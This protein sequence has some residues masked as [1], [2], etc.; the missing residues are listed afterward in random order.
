V[1]A[2]WLL[3]MLPLFLATARW[4]HRRGRP[5]NLGLLATLVVVAVLFFVVPF[6]LPR[7]HFDPSG[8]RTEVPLLL[9]LF[10][11]A[12]TVVPAVSVVASLVQVAHTPDRRAS[13]G[14]PVA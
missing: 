1:F 9:H 8:S 10:M 2:F 11:A 4:L 5:G 13:I 3:P 7:E 14:R 6:R 12:L